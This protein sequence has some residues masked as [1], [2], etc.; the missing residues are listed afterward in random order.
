MRFALELSGA[1]RPRLCALGTADGD[2]RFSQAFLAE[3]GEEVGVGVRFL[4]VYPMPNVADPAAFLLEHD[5]V[6]VGGGSVAN[7]LALW[8]L[9]R[10]DHA[11][12]AAWEAGVVLSGVSAGSICWHVGGTTD[13]FGPELQAV[14]DGLGLIPYAN[15]VHYDTEPQRRPALHRLIAG[16]TLPDGYATE[17]GVGLLYRADRLVEA[18]TE[19]PGKAAYAVSRSPEGRVTEERIEPRLLPEG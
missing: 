13:S 15:G 9:H 18:V 11:L 17:N 3:A 10:Y 16:G 5:V 8:R 6:W 7:L 2:Q 14:T 12:R 4:N 19:I 1:A